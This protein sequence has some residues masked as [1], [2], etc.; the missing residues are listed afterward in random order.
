MPVIRV[1]HIQPSAKANDQ[2]P[3][4]LQNSDSLFSVRSEQA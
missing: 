1:N 2:N 4:L 3:E